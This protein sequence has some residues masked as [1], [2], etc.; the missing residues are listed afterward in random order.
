MP[1]RGL[2]SFGD[3]HGIVCRAD[4]I[5]ACRRAAFRSR[6][7]L[8]FCGFFVTLPWRET[9]AG[10]QKRRCAQ[11]WRRSLMFTYERHLIIVLGIAVAVLAA[12][13]L[14]VVFELPLP[15]MGD[16]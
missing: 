6:Q 2:Q 15:F 8:G 3:R 16:A 11:S 4:Q 12:A 10:Q 9:P 13:I 1:G 7:L 5:P 14:V